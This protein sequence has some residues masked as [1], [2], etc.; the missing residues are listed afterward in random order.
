MERNVEYSELKKAWLASDF[1]QSL[2]TWRM[3]ENDSTHEGIP[4]PLQGVVIVAGEK[5]FTLLVTCSPC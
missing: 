2:I 5:G 3:C 1:E 4:A